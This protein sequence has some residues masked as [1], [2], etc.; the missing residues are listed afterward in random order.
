MLTRTYE[1]VSFNRGIGFVVQ[2]AILAD[3][4]DHHP[5]L[6]I[7]YNKIEVRLVTHSANGITDKDF[8]LAKKFDNAFGE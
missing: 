6:N 5:D 1:A 3:A 2:M 8:D 7:I 4:A